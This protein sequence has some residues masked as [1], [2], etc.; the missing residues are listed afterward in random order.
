[1]AHFAELD[2]NNVVL[3]VL[4][5]SNS[6]TTDANGNEIESIGQEFCH[7]LYGGNWIQTSYNNKIR[8]RYAVIGGTYRADLDAFIYP[9]PYPSWIF[10]EET[11][12]WEPP[13]PNPSDDLMYEWDEETVSWK[14]LTF[15]V[16]D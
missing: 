2:N 12:D 11:K 14:A 16:T 10:N 15:E 7:N 13:V 8:T 4:V 3:R 6:D 9:Q 1:M 5:I